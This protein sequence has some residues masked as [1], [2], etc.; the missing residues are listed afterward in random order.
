VL[1]VTGILV[2]IEAEAPEARPAD[3]REAQH[4]PK[5]APPVIEGQPRSPH[6]SQQRND[7]QQDA[8]RDGSQP[9]PVVRPL[10][11]LKTLQ[12]M[13]Q[14]RLMQGDPYSRLRSQP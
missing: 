1:L 9:P 2:G 12:E 7:T 6:G 8:G 14:Y 4:R 10:H 11:L 3:G 13:V 5:R